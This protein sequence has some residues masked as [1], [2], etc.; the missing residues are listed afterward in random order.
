LAGLK[1]HKCPSWTSGY[2]DGNYRV[3]AKLDDEG[4]V[5]ELR[6]RFDVTYGYDDESKEMHDVSMRELFRN[7]L[8]RQREEES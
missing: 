4:R 3:W 1:I 2:G 7:V 6:I 8:D 5:E